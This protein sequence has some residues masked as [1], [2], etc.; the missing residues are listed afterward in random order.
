MEA[1]KLEQKAGHTEPP[2]WYEP[3]EKPPG[4]FKIEGQYLAGEKFEGGPYLNWDQADA[5]FHQRRMAR[6]DGPLPPLK[7][8]RI[9]PTARRNLIAHA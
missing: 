1:G 7:S 4:P 8:Q 6:I 9:V 5:A 2:A 3:K